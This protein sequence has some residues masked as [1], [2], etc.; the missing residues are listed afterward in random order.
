VVNIRSEIII[1]SKIAK[2]VQ[3]HSYFGCDR[4]ISNIND[5][6]LIQKIVK[7]GKAIPVTGSGGP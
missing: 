3:N 7:A 1:D 4:P 6:D 5:R 2:Q